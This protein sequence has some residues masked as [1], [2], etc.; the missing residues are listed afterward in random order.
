[1]KHGSVK[2]QD[3]ES[4]NITKGCFPFGNKIHINIG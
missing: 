3:A 2:L 4:L 1:M